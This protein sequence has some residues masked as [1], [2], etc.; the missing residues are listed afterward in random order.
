MTDSNQKSQR[1][2]AKDAKTELVQK[3]GRKS[4]AKPVQKALAEKAPAKTAKKFV[5]P[6]AVYDVTVQNESK[7]SEKIIKRGTN[8][9]KTKKTKYPLR[10][11]P[12]GGLNE[13]GKN[14]TLYEY[15]SDCFIV[16]C[17]LAF[18]DDDMLGI[19]LVIPDFT[20]IEQIKDNLKA[21]FITHGHEDHIG[22]L[23]YL[24]KTV[25]VPVYATRLTV[26]L[27][28]A[29][30]REHGIIDIVQLN[31]INYGDIIDVGKMRVEAVRV[32]HSIP[33]ACAYAVHPPVG[34]VIQTG[35]FKIDYTPIHGEMIDLARFGE[36]G[37]HGVLA[38]LSDSTNAERPGSTGSERTV[39]Y[40][41]DRLFLTANK[42]RII[43]AS[44]ASNI[45]RIQQIIDMA[46]KFGRKV[47]VVGRSMV[48]VVNTAEELGYLNIPDNIFIDIDSVGSYTDDKIVI[49]TTG[50]QGEPMSA[51]TRMAMGDNKKVSIGPNDCIIISAT[52][53]PGN[54]KSV[55]I[56]I[57]E[58]M[59]LGAEVI[60]EKMYDI[61][62]SGHAC[63]D[64]LKT[65][66]GLTRPKFFIP[67]HGEY[68]HLKRHAGL[69]L[70]MEIPRE[71]IVIGEIGSVIETDGKTIKIAGT[72]PA[73][74]VMVDGLGV[75]DVGS[76]VLRDRKRLSEEGLI[77]VVAAIQIGSG[78][79]LAGPDIVSRGCVY[80]RESEE[81]MN[82]SREICLAA[83]QRCYDQ[84]VREWGG[85]KQT[86]K[87]ELSR[88]I[89]MKTKRTPMIL[90]V[91]QEI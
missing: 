90:P 37:R 84:N 55:D 9:S 57:N 74:Q 10:I 24:L 47:A 12:L 28:E 44:F 27:I 6:K 43:V 2:K 53:I 49:I 54:E 16:D 56:V 25:N 68:K 32:N 19:D 59:R 79:L 11:I 33:D 88:Y 51:L 50:S 66:I 31:V 86:I 20:Y 41:F 7:T 58:L 89:Y 73:G 65:I 61:H 40:S 18:P 14:I 72:V 46:Q 23:A 29:K 4:T 85:I 62:V 71:N 70:S 35:D 82:E 78:E 42:K 67:V 5:K 36:L 8:T 21:I 15:D 38:L 17:G 64:E 87:D 45:H 76:I 34:V 83:I 60:Y 1:K 13:I 80:G 69:A 81:I 48:N 77:I 22:A 75:G 63:Q 30:L 3:Q 52:P 39:G 91:I 26:G